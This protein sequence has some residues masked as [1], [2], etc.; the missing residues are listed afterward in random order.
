MEWSSIIELLIGSGG[1]ITLFLITEK[2]TAAM[3]KNVQTQADASLANMKTQYDALQ[4]LYDKLQERFDVET[5]K[6]GK[7]YGEI[8]ELH[9]K[10]DVA[11]T[12]AATNELKRCDYINCPNR[13]PPLSDQWRMDFEEKEVS[14]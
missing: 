11:N 8:E 1:L 9:N 6:V 5:D 13:R 7:L 4:T 10:L 14:E 12:K 3:I 2:K